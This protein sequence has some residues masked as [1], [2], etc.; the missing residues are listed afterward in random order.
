MNHLAST[1]ARLWQHRFAILL[2]GLAAL[3]L[4]GAGAESDLQAALQHVTA[5]FRAGDGA[6]MEPVLP[7]RG[8]I[9]VSLPNLA[10]SAAGFVS[11]SQFR[12]ILDDIFH[13]HEVKSFS[14]DPA[15][16]ARQDEGTSVAAQLELRRQDQEILRLSLQ[17][18]FVDTSEGW[19][20]REFREQA[21]ARP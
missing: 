12:Y 18:V 21:R 13:R 2:T 15:G 19:L 4:L 16:G 7:R 3:P 11:A 1:A 14:L 6:R 20:L 8:K 10:G 9:R 17:L 5:A